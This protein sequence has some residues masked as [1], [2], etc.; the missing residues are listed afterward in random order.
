MSAL[1]SWGAQNPK[2]AGILS[3]MGLVYG[4]KKV[5]QLLAT[6]KSLKGQVVL[7]TGGAN[8]LGKLMADK[9]YA[10]GSQVIVWDVNRDAVAQCNQ[11]SDNANGGSFFA[12]VVDITKRDTVQQEAKI[13]LDKFGRVDILV[14]NAGVVAGRPL[15]ELTE[16]DVRR[17]F[18]VNVIA[19]FWVLAAFLPG[20]IRRKQGHIV[21]IVSTAAF[22]AVSH[23][24]DYC[25]SKVAARA[26]DVGIKRELMDLEQDEG[27]VFT[28]VYP[29]F[30][31][32]G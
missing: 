23:L 5:Q 13:V 18:D 26:L 4:F 2:T 32:T 10:A 27:I 30:I 15:L 24:T 6:P 16:T 22:C 17:T 25:A 11:I 12:R 3:L 9:C 19:Q 14:Q 1:L 21:S 29:G 20:M 28:G 7:I 31:N 8:G